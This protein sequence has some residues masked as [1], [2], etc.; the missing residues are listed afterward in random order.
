MKNIV[1]LG[2]VSLLT[3]VSSEMVYPL[4]PLFLT[5]LGA[6]PSIIG[7]IEGIAESLASLLKVYSGYIADKYR[8]RKRLTIIGYGTSVLNKVLLAAAS[9]WAWVLCARVIDRFGKG[10]RTAPRDVLIAEA[11]KENE[12]GRAFGLHR[13]M[14]TL[15]AVIGVAIAF[16]LL[17]NY[18][19]DYVS[20]FLISIVPA[21]LGVLLLFFVKEKDS[22]MKAAKSISLK[23]SLLDGRLKAYLI[24]AFL[25]TLGNSSNQFLLLRASNAKGGLG[26]DSQTVI[27]LYLLYNV[28][29]AVLSYPAGRLS[30]KIGRKY[31][32]ISGY[33]LYGAV[34]L[35]FA[36]I[37]RKEYVW[38]LFAAYGLYIAAAEGVEKAFIADVAPEEL[39][40]TMLGLHA[41]LVGIG[42]LP[43]SFIAGVLWDVFNASAP[44][45]F[46]A[47][48][49]FAAALYLMAL[50]GNRRDKA[51]V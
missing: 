31:L 12:K 26:F 49:G 33:F 51:P 50:F 7:I 46:G 39:K 9:S 18:K 8:K 35:G 4:L 38:L 2:L 40:G 19:G 16:F 25:F 20:I 15:G 27:L 17:Q 44:F 43:A 37:T 47:F 13:A 6:T 11:A 5:G 14:D 45:Y 34:Y 21:A 36:L 28:V 1:I 29:Y 30:D 48:M 3:D 42:L 41:T 23:W 10:I 24:M 22:G 32:L